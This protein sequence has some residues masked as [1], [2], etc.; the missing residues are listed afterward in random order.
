MATRKAAI[1]ADDLADTP[2]S[3]LTADRF[4]ELLSDASISH[5]GPIVAD[6][7]KYE[8][9]IEEDLGGIK[10]GDF[11]VKLRAEKK[12]L[13]LEKQRILEDIVLKRYIEDPPDPR[14]QIV[15]PVIFE[16]IAQRLD[17]IEQQ[18]AARR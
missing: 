18:L 3:K 9:W 5:L 14:R 6:K 8:L 7:K 2:L 4:L 11:L 1:L 13:E 12:K 15:D 17:A 10:V 16:R